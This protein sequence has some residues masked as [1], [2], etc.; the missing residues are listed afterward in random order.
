MSK[1]EKAT[2]IRLE[3]LVDRKTKL[4]VE[5]LCYDKTPNMSTKVSWFNYTT[6]KNP[7]KKGLVDAVTLFEK[8]SSL[9]LY[10]NEKHPERPYK[11]KMEVRSK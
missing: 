5:G 4:K 1:E 8:Y 10:A 2:R 7:R 3:L 11:I 6:P 9:I